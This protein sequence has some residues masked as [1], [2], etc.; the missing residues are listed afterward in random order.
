MESSE[1]QSTISDMSRLGKR[2]GGRGHVLAARTF[3][4][5]YILYTFSSCSCEA[6]C[7]ARRAC[8]AVASRILAAA[9]P[10][11]LT[12]VVPISS[13]MSLRYCPVVVHLFFTG[14]ALGETS[15]P[16]FAIRDLSVSRLS[17]GSKSVLMRDG[18]FLV[19]VTV[20]E[21][22]ADVATARV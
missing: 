10:G 17:A 18:V 7:Q 19:E 4:S 13:C 2:I 3:P 6:R 21:W 11:S 20:L 8:I 22:S 16:Q 12:V 1:V 14:V 5:V 9:A 15:S